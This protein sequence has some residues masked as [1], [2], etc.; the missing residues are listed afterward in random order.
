MGYGH[1][2][3]AYPLREIAYER[4]ITANSDKIVTPDEEKQWKRFRRYYEGL[5][6]FTAVPIIGKLLFRLYDHFQNI[7]PFYPFRDLS[8]PTF[9]SWYMHK[10]IRKDFMKSLVDYV[11]RKDMPLIST[12]FA[13]ALAAAHRGLKDVYCIVTDTDINRVWVPEKPN[14]EKLYYLTP[15]ERSSRRLL[16]YGIKKDRIFFTGF[17]LPKENIGADAKILKQD[18]G[19][20]LP[21]L[22]P[23]KKYMSHYKAT[24]KAVLGKD[25]TEQKTHPLT[26]TFVVGGAGAQ[27]GIGAAILQSLRKQI[28]GHKIRVNL[29][30][31]TRIE[32][33][34]Y[35]TRKVSELHLQK[36]MDKYV[37]VMHALDKKTYFEKFNR[38]LRTTDILWT[39]PSEISFYTA[40][41]LPIII[42]PPLGA[43]EELNAKWLARL[44]SGFR[45]ENP[46]YVN[47]WLFDWL[48]KGILAEA[49]W[50]GYTE[51]PTF[52]T[53]NIEKIIF[54]KK[55]RDI[56]L[57]Y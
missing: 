2:R 45:Q 25:Y 57:K 28:L 33:F 24:L 46:L 1:Q 40:L 51:A 3:A 32:I 55:K 48:D 39:K 22:D 56:P 29:I 35:F 23:K 53:Y 8:K 10:M 52:G 49:A 4:I 19:K 27:K 26:L 34:E 31:G 20:R 54:D 42:A 37:T 6:R 17:P 5:S 50:E 30:P 41:G 9:I 36:E 15:T 44:G 18:L 12:F 47:E 16:Q 13:P 7:S 11:K 14:K 21:N 38:I 43:H